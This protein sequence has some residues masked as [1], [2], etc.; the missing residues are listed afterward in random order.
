MAVMNEEAEYK[1]H[2]RCVKLRVA[3]Q[4]QAWPQYSPDNKQCLST[5][6]KINRLKVLVLWDTGST[7][8]AMSPNCTNISKAI[9]FNLTTPVTLQLGTI[10]SRSKI[11]FGSNSEVEMPGYMGPE[12]FDIV[13][14]DQYSL[15]APS[16]CD[17]RLRQE[18]K[19]KARAKDIFQ[20]EDI[21]QLRQQWHD[22]YE[23]L[24]QGILLIDQDKWYH[25]HLPQC[26]NTLRDE[27]DDKAAP[28]MCMFKKDMHLHTVI[29][30]RQQNENTVKDVTPMPDQDNIREDIARARYRSKI[31][32][33][34]AYEQVWVVAS[35]VWKTTFSTI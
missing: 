11:N 34:D 6:M 10:G 13:N 7:S 5:W 12:Y 2:A 35:D 18:D 1:D 30:C 32:L 4:L 20:K 26:P 9:V 3:K 16:Q 8:M 31:D 23:E 19:G 15:Y 33:S 14:I 29:D 24:L 25:Y 28:M 21:P 27:F 17:T 22:E